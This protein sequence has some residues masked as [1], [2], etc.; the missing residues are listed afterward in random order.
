LLPA[1]CK[2]AGRHGSTSGLLQHYWVAFKLL[3]T[4][5]A[6]GVVMLKLSPM[7]A[8][9]A[10]AAAPDFNAATFALLRTSL[11]VHAAGGLA[12]LLAALA[13]DVAKPR[14]LAPW[15]AKKFPAPSTGTPRWV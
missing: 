8:F 13:L 1:H 5:V 15:G 7:D 12:V 10:A 2:G 11:L 14:G 6:T 9:T 4:V 3:L